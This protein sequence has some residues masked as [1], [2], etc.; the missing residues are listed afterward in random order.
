MNTNMIAAAIDRTIFSYA[1][2][3]L[4]HDQPRR[5]LLREAVT[6]HILDQVDQGQDDLNLLV[7]NA[8]KH[9]VSLEESRPELRSAPQK[10]F[11]PINQ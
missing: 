6:V 9:L 1:M 5:Q 2:M 7:V 3:G 10:E 8:L 11:A 4:R